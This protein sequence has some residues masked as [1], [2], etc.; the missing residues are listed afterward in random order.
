MHVAPVAQLVELSPSVVGSNP[1]QG[2][3]SFFLVKK[4]LLICL[5]YL[6]FL[7]HMQVLQRNAW[8]DCSLR[9]DEWREFCERQEVVAGDRSEL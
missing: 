6:A 5:F 8:S 4:E 9:C 1:T 3:S 2:S 7:R